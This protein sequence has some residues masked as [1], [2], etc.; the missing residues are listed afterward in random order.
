[1][2]TI[3]QDADALAELDDGTRRAW[4]S[5]RERLRE[6]TGAEYETAEGESWTELQDELSRID[7]RRRTLN[8]TSS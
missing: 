7:D 6:L 2:T 8:Q 3:A 5:Y 1:M 4:S